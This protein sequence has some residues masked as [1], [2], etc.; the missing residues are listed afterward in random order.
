[1]RTILYAFFVCNEWQM[2]IP[3][4]SENEKEVWY[5]HRFDLDG[6][7][8]LD[9]IELATAYTYFEEQLTEAGSGDTFIDDLD[10]LT[11]EDDYIDDGEDW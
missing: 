7:G 1:M 4:M 11:F 10:D 3:Y 8:N 2:V 5:V 6:D 9:A